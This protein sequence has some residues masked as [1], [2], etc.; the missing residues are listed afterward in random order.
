MSVR[1]TG[2]SPM[3][4]EATV[5]FADPDA[6]SHKLSLPPA[7]MGAEAADDAPRRCWGGQWR[8]TRTRDHRLGDYCRWRCSVEVPIL[9]KSV[10]VSFRVR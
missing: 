10:K 5:G 2:L 9:V 8:L 3:G 4:A 1:Q 7:D 6:I